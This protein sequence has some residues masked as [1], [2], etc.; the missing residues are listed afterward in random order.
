MGRQNRVLSDV[1]VSILMSM[2]LCV[3]NIWT[4][5]QYLVKHWLVW[6]FNVLFFYE[7][8][9]NCIG[10]SVYSDFHSFV[11]KKNLFIALLF[12]AVINDAISREFI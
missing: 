6:T 10:P 1:L 2:S 9:K 5:S 3:E 8:F 7:T 11:D 4:V 12:I